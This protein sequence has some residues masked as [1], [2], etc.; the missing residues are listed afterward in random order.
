[1]PTDATVPATDATSDAAVPSA[2]PA[3]VEPQAAP[4]ATP[5]SD[6][7][8]T[9]RSVQV[10]TAEGVTVSDHGDG[11]GHTH[12]HGTAPA[13]NAAHAPREEEGDGA[14]EGESA[15]ADAADEAKEIADADDVA[16]ADADAENTAADG[17]VDVADAAAGTP[18]GTT[19]DD[20][21][22]DGHKAA[23]GAANTAADATGTDGT[24]GQAGTADDDVV[25]DADG[26]NVTVEVAGDNLVVTDRINFQPN[27]SVLVPAARRVLNSVARTLRAHPLISLVEVAGHC[28]DSGSS[29]EQ[30]AFELQ[31]SEARAAAV[32]AHLVRCGVDPAR[33]VARG[34][35]DTQPVA[36]NKT[37]EGRALNR[38]VEFVILKRHGEHMPTEENSENAPAPDG[39]DADDVDPPSV[40]VG[41][42]ALQVSAHI[43]FEPNT[44]V[45]AKTAARALRSIAKTL[46]AHPNITLVEVA[47]HCSNSGDTKADNAFEVKLSQARATAV[48][49]AVI[50]Y[51]VD[52]GRLVAKG[53]GDT[54]PIASN[55]TADGRA[56]N[57][58]VEFVIL[59]Q[60]S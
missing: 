13:D 58:R 17:A 11:H 4:D 41:A 6:P 24:T 39:T 57:R 28:S 32:V 47:G 27:T 36:T 29:K 2:D 35:G 53:Y 50:S 9:A 33:L 5:A 38:R 54:V 22:G 45:L 51:G 19:P 48:M 25:E 10:D 16:K 20:A 12:G 7:V 49:N 52:A 26:L 37:A 55:A 44:A 18:N 46:T 40:V 34:Y 30:D 23:D 21:N 59:K 60:D 3:A 43:N 56:Q 31:L 14:A 1:M 8:D 42:K 15:A